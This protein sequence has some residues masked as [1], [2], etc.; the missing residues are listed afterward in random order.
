M[1]TSASAAA[2][3]P[4]D[5]EQPG[6]GDPGPS[7]RRPH[8]AALWNNARATRTRAANLCAAARAVAESSAELV[9]S[10]RETERRLAPGGG[11]RP[12][13]GDPEA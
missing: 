2:H 12:A 9:E 5:D 4:P 1:S 10:L 11:R 8:N 3:R 6:R 13:P 7:S